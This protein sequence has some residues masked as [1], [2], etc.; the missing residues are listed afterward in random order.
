[1]V[2]EYGGNEKLQ[3]MSDRQ[4]KLKEAVSELEST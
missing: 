2:V 1:M 4:K 3:E